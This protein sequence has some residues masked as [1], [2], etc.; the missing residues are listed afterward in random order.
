M[1]LP[2]HG[3]ARLGY[4]LKRFISTSIKPLTTK[5]YK[6]VTQDKDPPTT[7]LYNILIPWS[8]EVMW[9]RKSVISTF[10]RSQAK[11]LER[12]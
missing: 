2:L 6:V 11:K 3:H 4:K 5:L 7:K 10:S 12:G 9:Q 8:I 1:T